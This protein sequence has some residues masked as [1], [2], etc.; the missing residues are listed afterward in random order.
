MGGA[1]SP[2]GGGGAE[3][4][5][6]GLEP[7]EG[8]QSLQ[9]GAQSPWG[10]PRASKEG[11]RARRGEGRASREGPSPWE[12][13]RALAG[14]PEPPGRGAESLSA[15]VTTFSPSQVSVWRWR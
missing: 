4:P 8:A 9:G 3:P 10:W 15:Q 12:G 7:L 6:R 11:P 13:P 2:R 1:Q 5:A 14:G